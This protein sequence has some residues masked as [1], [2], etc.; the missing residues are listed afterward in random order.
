MQ[1]AGN[2]PALPSLLFYSKLIAD[3]LSRPLTLKLRLVR[4]PS[5]LLVLALL[6]TLFIPIFFGS[7]V[8]VGLSVLVA[9]S[10]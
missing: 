3:A 9:A 5:Q 4:T 10:Y 7:V 6:R 8:F 2:D 1:V